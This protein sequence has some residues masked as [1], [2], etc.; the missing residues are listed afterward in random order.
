MSS[1]GKCFGVE[2]RDIAFIFDIDVHVAVAVGD[3]LFRG[4]MRFTFQAW[5]N[6]CAE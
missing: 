2:H 1:H 6:S 3:G 5:K 4:R